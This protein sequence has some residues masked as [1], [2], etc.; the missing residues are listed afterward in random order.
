MDKKQFR[1]RI[2]RRWQFF[3]WSAKKWLN[4]IFVCPFVNH[5]MSR[6]GEVGCC[7]KDGSNFK[8]TEILYQCNRCYINRTVNII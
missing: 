1:R 7:D 4:K 2:R 8:K 6:I 3:K 5:E